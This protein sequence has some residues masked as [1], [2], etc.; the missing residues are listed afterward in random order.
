MNKRADEIVNTEKDAEIHQTNN[1]AKS[2]KS[3]YMYIASLFFIVFLFILLSYFIQQRNNSELHLLSEKNA[4][5]QQKIENLQADNLRLKDENLTYQQNVDEME[6]QIEALEKQIKEVRANWQDDVDNVTK[7][8]LA[9]YN[10]LFEKYV[11]LL[12]KNEAEGK[13]K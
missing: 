6:K 12:E 11:E 5:A 4:S 1:K 2:K 10:A 9:Q 3:V 7:N 13:T 8:Y